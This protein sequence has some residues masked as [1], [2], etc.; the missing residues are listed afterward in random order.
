MLVDDLGSCYAGLGFIHALYPHHPNRLKDYI[1]QPKSNGYQSLHTVVLPEGRQVEIQFRTREM[2][3][4]AE[5]GLRHTGDTKRSSS[6]FE[7]RHS[8]DCQL[9]AL[10]EAAQELTDGQEFLDAV[11]VELFSQEVFVFTPAGDVRIFP[12]GATLLDFA[13]SIHTDLGA[14]CTGGIVDGRIVSLRYTLQ[15]GTTLKS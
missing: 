7:R 3:R 2:H 8:E 12:V 15:N 6:P 10:F 1:A 13:Y 14:K 4:V 5:L 11:K 9:R